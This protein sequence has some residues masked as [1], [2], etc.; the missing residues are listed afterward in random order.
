MYLNNIEIV[1]TAPFSKGIGI[2]VLKDDLTF[3][4]SYLSRL[5][6]IFSSKLS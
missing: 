1:P 6:L 2:A 5:I 3:D 4:Y